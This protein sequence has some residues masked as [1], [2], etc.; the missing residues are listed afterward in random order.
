VGTPDAAPPPI[1]PRHAEPSSAPPVVD[2]LSAPAV[3]SST[4]PL[5][6]SPITASPI[7]G[8]STTAFADDSG[9]GLATA[10]GHSYPAG[11]SGSLRPAG[12]WP[13]PYPPDLIA[14]QRP[15][16]RR[17]S[18]ALL[19]IA[20]VVAFFAIVSVAAS[21]LGT[22][23]STATGRLGAVSAPSKA[24]VDPLTLNSVLAAQSKALIAGDESGFLAG[25]DPASK[26]VRSAYRRMYANL[27]ALH[28]ASWSQSTPGGGSRITS[29]RHFDIDVSYCLVVTT[30]KDMNA[31]LSVTAAVKAGR[32]LIESYV[33]PATSER[34]DEPI[35]WETATL[36]AV[37]GR[38]VVVAAASAE[39][40]ELADALPVAERAAAAAD[41]YAKWGKPPVYLIYLAGP[42][43]AK[44]WFGGGLEHST[45]EAIGLSATDIE[46]MVVLPAAGE[47]R[48]AGP[49][50]LGTVIQH[51]MGHVVTLYGDEQNTGHD[52][53][54]EGIAEFI[55]YNGHSNW[56]AYRLD[57]TREYLQNGKWSGNCY[58]TK[59]IS[60]DDVL[61]GSAAY[62]IGY[63]TFKRLA[64]KYGT[65]KMLDF[66]GGVERDGLTADQSA[67]KT[68]GVGWK[69]VNADCASYIRRT[70]HA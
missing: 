53:F 34:F 66:W 16:P 4:I 12:G 33:P 27:R 37:T 40:S 21:R 58:L 25:V 28:V 5:S 31:Q 13:P 63:L 39:K 46:V 11:A 22:A 55:A 59:E 29:V 14:G 49:G 60:S 69:T 51:E 56:A 48:Y 18:V 23:T 20:I 68:F 9:N 36:T 3:A 32:V 62:G 8:Y 57:N 2:P 26:I 41:K 64:S 61:T 19:V 67:R 54:I 10:V 1:G 50:R 38:R 7:T 15:G 44:S 24:P 35:P 70:L 30:C 47:S 52:S 17:W 45:G 6:G 42:S 43:D 65:T